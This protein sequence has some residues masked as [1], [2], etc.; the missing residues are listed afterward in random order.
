M[1]IIKGTF[2]DKKGGTFWINLREH[3]NRR[4]LQYFQ[5]IENATK[6]NDW[7]TAADEVLR[8]YREN[9]HREVYFTI[10]Q[11]KEDNNE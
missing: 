1:Y 9:K 5:F 8:L 10:E 2:T 4:I 11:L 6:F 7:N 3:L